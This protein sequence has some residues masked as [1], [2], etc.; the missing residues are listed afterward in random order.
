MTNHRSRTILIVLAIAVMG[1]ASC[2]PSG[3]DFASG[4]WS[5]RPDVAPESLSV[6]QYSWGPGVS[7]INGSIDID[8]GDAHPWLRIGMVGDTCDVTS[9]E[10]IDADTMRLAFS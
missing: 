6:E 4:V 5:L 1:T 8:L 2:Q 3:N 9:A 10:T 7:V